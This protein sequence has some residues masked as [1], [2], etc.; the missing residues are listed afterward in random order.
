MECKPRSDFYKLTSPT[1]NASGMY[2]N[3]FI[4]GDGDVL[5]GFRIT[6]T[7]KMRLDASGNLLVGKTSTN[8]SLVGAN[9][10]HRCSLPQMVD[11]GICHI[12]NRLNSDGTL[13]D[14]QQAGTSEGTISV[15]GTQLQV[16]GS[17]AP[18]DFKQEARLGQP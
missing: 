12:V 13:I 3:G 17:M 10:S 9:E 4:S 8:T 1:T 7:N 15:S 16:N 18:S 14:F 6:I 2:S 5:D 11:G